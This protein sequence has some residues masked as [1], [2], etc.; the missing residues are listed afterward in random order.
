MWAYNVVLAAGAYLIVVGTKGTGDQVGSAGEN[1]GATTF[2]NQSGTSINVRGGY[3][4]GG[5]S[6]AGGS[7]GGGGQASA[8][9]LPGGSSGGVFSQGGAGGTAGA[10]AGGF[11][12]GGAGGHYHESGNPGTQGT[13]G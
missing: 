11:Y 12:F 5:G 4:G 6:N 8:A 2:I 1:G 3:A 10:S 13:P 9:T 7:S